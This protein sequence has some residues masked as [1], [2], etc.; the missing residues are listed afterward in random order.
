MKFQIRHLILLAISTLAVTN[1]GWLLTKMIVVGEPKDIPGGVLRYFT[2][3]NVII[4]FVE[5]TLIT[6]SLVAFFINGRKAEV[7]P[8]FWA[9]RAVGEC[10]AAPT[11]LAVP[12][13]Y[14]IV[15]L[16]DP[17]LVEE[18]EDTVDNH[19]KHTMPIVV[20]LPF[21]LTVGA[22]VAKRWWARTAAVV[23]GG[24]YGSWALYLGTFRDHFPYPG[25]ALVYRWNRPLLVVILIL[26]FPAVAFLFTE[27]AWFIQKKAAEHVEW[28]TRCF[29]PFVEACGAGP[30]LR[31]LNRKLSTA[32]N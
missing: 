14:W 6:T 3:W 2:N 5:S 7:R 15:A 20:A 13:L 4:Q 16:K 12:T 29:L 9:A 31:R 22:P 25:M 10:V 27:L 28:A 18:N 23:V 30:T 11:A 19:M 17:N 32:M 24:G 8:L 26:G 1:F 21:L